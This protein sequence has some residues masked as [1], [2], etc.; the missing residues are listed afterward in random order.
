MQK[1]GLVMEFRYN[2]DGIRTSKTV[3]GIEHVYTLNGSQIVSEA[4]GDYLLIYLYDESGSPIGM[5]YRESSYA[6]NT[7]DTF[8]FEKNLQGDIIAVYNENGVKIVSY[9]YDAWGNHTYTWHNTAGSNILAAYNPF[10]YR[11][12]YYDTDTQLYYLQSRYYNPQWGR[13]LNADGYI[14]ANGDLIGFNM[15]AYCS[16]N[17]VMYTDPIGE[18]AV[19]T[20]I[21]LIIVGAA[22]LTTVGAT[23]YGA[24][25]DTPVVLDISVSG[26][27]GA[28]V[29][30]KVGLSIVLD[31]KNDSMGFYPH[32][33][34]YYGAKY[35]SFGFSYGVGLI[36][37]YENEG[38]YSGPFTN[39]GGGFFGGVDH[40]Y[41]PRYPYED[42]VRAS[43]LTFGNNKGIYY[44]YDYYD[45][46]GS[47]SFS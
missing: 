14:N 45:Y 37:N 44:G 40:C 39:M 10:R 23:A 28:G 35:N 15:Y 29:G 9:N 30:G 42:T 32:Y 8:Y 43:S 22:I 20:I 21:T 11:G 6:A 33:G 2:A 19:S 12:Y 25:T 31:F 41:D 1:S 47:I 5:Q 16:N 36:S 3:G 38:D 13:F 27:M 24:T 7:F 46:W 4:W 34:Y 17:P 26:G 18:L